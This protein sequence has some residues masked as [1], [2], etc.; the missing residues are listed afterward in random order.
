MGVGQSLF[1]F[2]TISNS[3]GRPR[4]IYGFDTFEGIPDPTSEDGDWNAGIRGDWNYSQERVIE[5]LLLSGLD[6][7]FIATYI[8]LVPGE[9]ASTLPHLQVKAPYCSVAYRCGYLRIIQNI[10]RKPV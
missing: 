4:H 8:T 6:E 10:P 5:N 9:F 7:E 3:I 1:H 2:S